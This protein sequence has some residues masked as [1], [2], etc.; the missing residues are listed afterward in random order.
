METLENTRL[1]LTTLLRKQEAR[2]L[3]SFPLKDHRL[4]VIELAR[5]IDAFLLRTKIAG[6][7]TDEELASLYGTGWNKALSL[8]LD[9]SSALPGFP[10]AK[11]S[12]EIQGWANSVL[13][14][15][16]RVAH[17]ERI[18]DLCKYGLGTLLKSSTGQYH[19]RYASTLI[20]SEAVETQEAVWQSTFVRDTIQK[21][22]REKLTTEWNTIRD[23]MKSVVRPWRRH[24]ISYAT[25]PEIDS[26]YQM[27]GVLEAQCMLGQDSFPGEAKF[28][29]REFNLYRA[30]IGLLIGWTLKHIGFASILLQKHS[31][32]D[33]R[34]LV[35]HFQDVATLTGYVSS[36]LDIDPQVAK[37]G[38]QP[39]VLSVENK[40]RRCVPGNPVPPLIQ[41]AKTHFLWPITGFLTTP[42]FFMLRGLRSLYSEDWDR[43]VNLHEEAFRREIYHLFPQEHMVK[44]DRSVNLNAEEGRLTDLDAVVY[45][46]R[47]RTTGI[48]QLKWQEPWAGSMRERESRKKNFLKSANEWVDRVDRWVR[49]T[50]RSM[51]A[52]Q[53][54]L[55]ALGV[56]SVGDVRLFVIGRNFSH[57]SG[58]EK[59]DDRA[60][61]G[62]WIQLLRLADREY[63]HSDPVNWLFNALKKDSPTPKPLPSLKEEKITLEDK[64]IV[65]FPP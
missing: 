41:I 5:A 30:T 25:T 19:F 61:W 9:D 57:F 50:D 28:G 65:L 59:P 29:G 36:A 54:G 53:L 44:L 3:Q 17:C 15:C 37:Q 51:V 1:E 21:A 62:L 18:L 40:F 22:V 49:N 55:K 26:Y 2:I 64:V 35:T 38:L 23:L 12:N 43:A 11:S 6:L 52:Q 39:L 4:A 60:A 20:G 58:D 16:G 42:F 33:V 13:Q 34:N 32:L 8:F 46:R 24:F 7:E 56:R 45:D 27:L 47:A 63:D 10:L 31:H 14:H 48:F